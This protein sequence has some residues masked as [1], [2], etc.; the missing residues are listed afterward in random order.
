MVQ[1]MKQKMMIQYKMIQN[2]IHHSYVDA[3]KDVP[4]DDKKMIEERWLQKK[5]Q[6]RSMV[7]MY[8]VAPKIPVTYWV[9]PVSCI[10]VIVA[11]ATT[12]EYL[13]S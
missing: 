8:D 9:L 12:V 13:P 3:A 5:V 1:K 4:E 7:K 2:M 11:V 6:L 10:V